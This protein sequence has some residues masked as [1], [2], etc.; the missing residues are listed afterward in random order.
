MKDATRI[1][2]GL[3]LH[4]VSV[5]TTAEAGLSGSS[6]QS[7]LA[8]AAAHGRV[9]VTHD[10]DFLRLQAAGARHAGIAYS[11]LQHRSLGDVVRLLVM[12]WELLE[13][14]EMIDRVEFL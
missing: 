10:A 6:D 9:I 3:R 1:A 7:Q 11:S 4:G 13:S 2:A 8:Y 12:V 14:A 5:T